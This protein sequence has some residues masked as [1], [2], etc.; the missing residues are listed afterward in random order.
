MAHPIP[1]EHVGEERR[2]MRFRQMRGV[3]R[4]LISDL[5]GEMLFLLAL[6]ALAGFVMLFWW[7][8]QLIGD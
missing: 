4:G 7:I 6:L 1:D 3:Y 5:R 8:K 2:K